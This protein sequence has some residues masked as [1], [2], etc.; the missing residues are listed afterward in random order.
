VRLIDGKNER[1]GMLRCP[2]LAG[3]PGREEVDEMA[4]C[5]HDV[6]ANGFCIWQ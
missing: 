4:E 5:A 1:P 2:T 3:L 6:F